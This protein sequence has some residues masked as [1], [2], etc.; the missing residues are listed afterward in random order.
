MA[1]STEIITKIIN[2]KLTK[3]LKIVQNNAIMIVDK[4]L[5]QNIALIQEKVGICKKTDKTPAVHAP[6]IGKGTAV[7]RATL[8]HF[9]I[10]VFLTLLVFVFF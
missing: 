9:F 6:D 5:P 3:S 7:K 1:T 8:N 2:T 4:M 10:F